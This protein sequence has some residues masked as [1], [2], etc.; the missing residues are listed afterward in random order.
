PPLI[1]TPDD[2]E[3]SA[4]KRGKAV[5]VGAGCVRCHVPPL[6]T[7]PASYDV[8][9]VDELGNVRFNPPSLRG[10]SQRAPLLHDGRAHSLEQVIEVFRH[11]LDAGLPK[12]QAADLL[13]FLR[14]I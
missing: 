8:G 2:A 14:S 13:R 11:R 7:T 5:F 4:I 6:Y 10:V 1:G 3:R 9:L 12:D